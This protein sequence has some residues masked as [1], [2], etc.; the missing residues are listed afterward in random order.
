MSTSKIN[1]VDCYDLAIVGAGLSALSVL[2]GL[3]EGSLPQ[4]TIVLEH[5]LEAGSLLRP[6]LVTPA[7]EFADARALLQSTMHPEHISIRYGATVVGLIPAF[8]EGEPHTLVVR[9]RQG[10]VQIQARKVLI[11]SGGLELTREHQRIPG[12]RPA[13]VITPI[14]AHQLLSRGY[15]PGRRAIVYGNSLYATVTARRLADAGIQVSSL[16]PA[17]HNTD[18]E[19]AAELVEIL[20]FP[21]LERVR[22]RRG[23]QLF[24][25]PADLLVYAVGMMANTH[26]LKG[27]GLTLRGDGTIE[28]DAQYRTSIWGIYAVGTVIAP[29]L[30]HTD[31]ISMGKEVASLLQ[32]GIL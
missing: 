1:V 9:M 14:L 20:G 16:V 6:L 31:S 32:E 13:G 18:T 10:T 22:L 3:R 29:S 21:R 19:A 7:P 17:S 2:N 26:W 28:V 12:T 5:R 11:A 30:D 23:E 27:S 8:A 24:E 25:L 4:H 15:L